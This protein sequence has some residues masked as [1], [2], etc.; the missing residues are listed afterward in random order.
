MP[1]NPVQIASRRGRSTAYRSSKD[2]VA[3]ARAGVVSVTMLPVLILDTID[4]V[5]WSIVA[6]RRPAIRILTGC[7]YPPSSS[8]VET[9][10]HAADGAFGSQRGLSAKEAGFQGPA[11]PMET[12]SMADSCTR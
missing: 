9:D 5:P 1:T 6:P 11:V 8:S 7:T 4:T 10:A 3:S 12:L 2:A